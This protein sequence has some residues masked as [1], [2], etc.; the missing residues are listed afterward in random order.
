MDN[1]VSM[2]E[3]QVIAFEEAARKIMQQLS[4]GQ[5][6]IHDIH[7]L[8]HSAWWQK[9]PKA[10]QYS[11]SGL[12]DGADVFYVQVNFKQ[13][14]LS[15]DVMQ[16]HYVLHWVDRLGHSYHVQQGRQDHDSY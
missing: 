16:T 6:Q 2:H 9:L 14:K 12:D 15:F 13:L 8:M 3:Q 4:L 5:C 1:L 11:M 10:C 7:D